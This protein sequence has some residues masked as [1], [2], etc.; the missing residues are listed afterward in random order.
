MKGRSP[1]IK[2]AAP[3]QRGERGLIWN[4]PV[5]RFGQGRG[6]GYADHGPPK[7]RCRATPSYALSPFCRILEQNAVGMTEALGPQ[8]IELCKIGTILP[9]LMCRFG[10]KSTHRLSNP[11]GT[12]DFFAAIL[13]TPKGAQSR[14]VKL[15]QVSKCR[16]ANTNFDGKKIAAPFGAAVRMKK[17]TDCTEKPRA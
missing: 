16:K 8:Q 1:S 17:Q 14:R 10:Y 11:W 3:P 4:V 6:V 13:H 5:A 9:E 12:R 7:R 2:A 15:R